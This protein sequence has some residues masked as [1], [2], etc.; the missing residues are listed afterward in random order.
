M[1]TFVPGL[2]EARRAE[3]A[4][5]FRTVIRKLGC[6]APTPDDMPDDGAVCGSADKLNGCACHHMPGERKRQTKKRPPFPDNSF[7]RSPV[8]SMLTTSGD[9]RTTRCTV[10]W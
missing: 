3:P 2:S 6:C 9:T 10:S 7:N 1:A 8:I 4:P 5:R